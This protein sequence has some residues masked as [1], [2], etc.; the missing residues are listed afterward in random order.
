MQNRATKR[1]PACCG[2]RRAQHSHAGRRQAAAAGGRQRR[3]AAAAESSRAPLCWAP[4]NH[5][6]VTSG[7]QIPLL[8]NP[9]LERKSSCKRPDS[10]MHAAGSNC[11]PASGHHLPAA[12]CPCPPSGGRSAARRWPWHAALM[13]KN[14]C[15]VLGMG[16]T[17]PT[18][19][20]EG[21]GRLCRR[22]REARS[23][24][25]ARAKL[26]MA[27]QPTGASVAGLLCPRQL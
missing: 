9:I 7:G 14:P 19:H 3:Q 17:P 18:E 21:W 5:N 15:E 10:I 24:W 27:Q 12:C 13:R 6:S 11:V 22:W 25:L 20:P 8:P 23:P 4:S 16:Q 1:E 2:L 26:R